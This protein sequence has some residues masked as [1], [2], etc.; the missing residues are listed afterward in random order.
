M[1]N[2]FWVYEKDRFVS[3]E[4]LK[5]IWKKKSQRHGEDCFIEVAVYERMVR[6]RRPQFRGND[7][8]C[9]DGFIGYPE[10]NASI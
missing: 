7:M 8:Y 6:A 3:K 4:E 9:K 5:E 10:Y 2:M 1:S